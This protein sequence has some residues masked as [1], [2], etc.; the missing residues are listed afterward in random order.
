MEDFGREEVEAA[1]YVVVQRNFTIINKQFFSFRKIK[2]DTII[3]Y[4]F[5]FLIW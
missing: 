3:C 1:M 5:L 2:M 4:F